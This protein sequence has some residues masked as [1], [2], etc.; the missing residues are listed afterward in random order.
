MGSFVKIIVAMIS[1]NKLGFDLSLIVQAFALNVGKHSTELDEWLSVNPYELTASQTELLEDLYLEVEED[2]NYWNEEELKVQ[3]VGT[4]FR[5]AQITVPHKIKIFYERP[6][7]AMVQ[8][9]DLSVIT[10]CLIATPLPFNTPHKP[11]FFLQEF[12]K[13]RGEKRDPE[14]QMLTA[15]LIAQELNADSKPLYG[16]YLIGH[17]WHF[18]TLLG[19]RYTASRQYDATDKSDL[20]QIVYILRKL[21]ELLTNR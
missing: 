18:A 10:D 8:N 9:Y 14:A 2:G 1:T 7:A 5:I 6:L 21:K 19:N 11:Y 3:F 13:K 4:I 20:L 17:N 12:K 16:G 15:M